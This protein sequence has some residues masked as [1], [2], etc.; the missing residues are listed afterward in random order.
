MPDINEATKERVRR[1]LKVDL[2]ESEPEAIAWA[3]KKAK[4]KYKRELNGNTE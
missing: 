3:V 2:D 1:E 4:A